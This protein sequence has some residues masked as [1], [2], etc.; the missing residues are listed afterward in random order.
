VP[1]TAEDRRKKRLRKLVSSGKAKKLA[2]GGM[3]SITGAGAFIT[4]PI[5][6]RPAKKTY[7]DP[8]KEAVAETMIERL[9]GRGWDLP[10][11][12]H[13]QV[14]YFV[15]LFTNDP[16]ARDRLQTFLIRSGRYLPMISIKLEEKDMPHDLIFLAMME[17]GF[18]PQARSQKAASGLWQFLAKTGRTMGLRVDGEVDERN[19][20]ER[21]TEAA[22]DYLQYL[23]D[24]FGSWYLAAAAY[25][26]GEGR[27][28]KIMKQV[29]GSVKATSEED[30]YRIWSRL[31]RETRNYVP[32]MIAAARI[33]KNPAAYGYDHLVP[34]EPISAEE[35][36]IKPGTTLAEVAKESNADVQELRRLNPYL[37]KG[38]VPRDTSY[39]IK[40][41]AAAAS[42]LTDTAVV[43]EVPTAVSVGPERT[44]P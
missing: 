29:T 22:L 42:R 1:V 9:A 20:P 35:V 31:P 7:D 21:S 2:L 28:A 38:R 30:Y 19:H 34:E 6:P 4:A 8:V 11:L 15:D 41:P 44:I 3:L 43:V 13:S 33:A 10:N 36:E 40:V 14:D 23:H 16:E 5:A 39:T 26:A 18:D 37:T 32:Q 17:S 27:I 25:N 24:R 12:D